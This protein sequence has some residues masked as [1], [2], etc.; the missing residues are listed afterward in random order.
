MKTSTRRSRGGR[1]R[2][3]RARTEDF[4]LCRAVESPAQK[5]RAPR[6]RHEQEWT[7]EPLLGA[8]RG[9]E[10]PGQRPRSEGDAAVLLSEHDIGAG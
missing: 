4:G 3:S 9:Q 8:C 2:G 1:G 5:M 10:W 6:V 7:E